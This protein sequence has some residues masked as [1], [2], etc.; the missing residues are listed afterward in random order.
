MQ[1][2]R[3]ELK[4]LDEFRGTFVGTFERYGSKPNY[5]GFQD[6]TILLIN[7]KDPGDA[8]EPNKIVA[9]HLWFNL[10]KGFQALGELKKGDIIEFRARVCPYLKGFINRREG[11]NKK[12][13]DY[14]LS[15]PTKIVKINENL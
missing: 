6:T 10:T 15:H 9:D 2:M 1:A 12:K 8:K 14:K 11:L 5:H 4:N 13:L 7:I 3:K